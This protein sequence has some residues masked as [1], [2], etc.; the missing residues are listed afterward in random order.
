MR[1][2]GRIA[3]AIAMMSTLVLAALSAP[4]ALAGAAPGHVGSDDARTGVV[5]ADDREDHTPD[6]PTAKGRPALGTK[7][8]TATRAAAGSR[9]EFFLYAG[10]H[11]R[12]IRVDGARGSYTVE[13]PA[14]AAAD[15]HSLGELSVADATERQI[16]EIGWTVDRALFGDDYP[17]LFVFHWVDGEPTCYNGCGFV[18]GNDPGYAV[19]MRLPTSTTPVQF[20]ILHR[21]SEWLLGYNGHWVGSFPDSL[22]GNRFKVGAAVQ[23]FGEVASETPT[24]CTA[25]G[26]GQFGISPTAARVQNIGFWPGHVIPNIQINAV[27]PTMYAAVRTGPTSFRYGG[28]GDCRTVP[29]L[30]GAPASSANRA[31]TNA[32]L[33]VGTVG[34]VVD[35]LCEDIGRILS[36]SPSAGT[37]RIPGGSAVSYKYGVEPRSG[38]PDAPQ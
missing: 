38:C 26:N 14:L 32:G 34:T 15:Y 3:I 7:V 37:T 18:P 4:G 25:M 19:G 17:H 21:G 23:W 20:S 5:T 16:V 1:A 31:I 9:P 13:K 30:I 6:V 29:N 11:Q 33:V 28:T 36:Q 8:A 12:G 24:P 10:A 22:W 2:L 27:T 35:P